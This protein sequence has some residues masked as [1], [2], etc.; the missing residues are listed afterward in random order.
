MLA[1]LKTFCGGPMMS[2][3]GG[4]DQQGRTEN[5]FTMYSCVDVPCLSHYHTVPAKMTYQSFTTAP[6]SKQISALL[7]QK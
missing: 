6:L 7:L 1:N 5:N 3:V 2:V 4:G